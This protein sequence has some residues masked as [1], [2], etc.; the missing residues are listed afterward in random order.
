MIAGDCDQRF[1]WQSFSHDS[2]LEYGRRVCSITSAG[3]P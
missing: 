2:L 1:E 3:L